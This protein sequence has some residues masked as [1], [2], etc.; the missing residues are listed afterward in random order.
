MASKQPNVYHFGTVR[1]GKV[2][3]SDLPKLR[4]HLQQFE[5]QEIRMLIERKPKQ[6]KLRSLEQNAY[7]HGIV[8]VIFGDHVGLNKDEAHDALRFKFLSKDVEIKGH[9]LKVIRS[10]ADLS[11]K[12]F[13]EYLS[14]VRMWAS[15]EHGCYIPLPRECDY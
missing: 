2:E 7:Y 13:E 5:G 6:R 4:H 1:D 14:D 15:I 8:C 10:T 9:K 12:E 11:T 3:F